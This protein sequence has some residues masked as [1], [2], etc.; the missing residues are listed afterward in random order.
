MRRSHRN[1]YTTHGVAIVTGCES[2]ASR[3]YLKTTCLQPYF[4]PDNKTPWYSDL[5]ETHGSN[6]NDLYPL[7]PSVEAIM[8]GSYRTGIEAR[9]VQKLLRNP[10]SLRPSRGQLRQRTWS[11]AAGSHIDVSAMPIPTP[12]L[13]LLG[14]FCSL[15]LF[16]LGPGHYDI[17]LTG[18]D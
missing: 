4:N 10:W 13:D 11:T 15:V 17:H 7:S 18:Q 2:F 3:P 8:I 5:W 16:L 12:I 14:F 6:T 9:R 1:G